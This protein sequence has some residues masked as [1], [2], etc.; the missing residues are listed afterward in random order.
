VYFKIVSQAGIAIL[1]GKGYKRLTAILDFLN[2]MCPKGCAEKFRGVKESSK[3]DS[4]QS[5]DGFGIFLCY[6]KTNI[7]DRRL[8]I[9]Y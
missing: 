1:T 3:A 7:P 6:L 5:Q 8:L 2:S 9:D 4:F